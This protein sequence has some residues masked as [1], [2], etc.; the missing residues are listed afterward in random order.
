MTCKYSGCTGLTSIEISN[1][2]TSIGDYAFC[3]CTGLTSI[4]IPNSVISIGDDAFRG[5]TGL[6]RVE[7]NCP[8]VDCCWSNDFTY[9]ETIIEK[10]CGKKEGIIA[11]NIKLFN[12]EGD[13]LFN[14]SKIE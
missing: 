10:E 7:L 12:N 13:I 1:S 3:G 6:K 5:C 9:T 4:T 11:T 14:S 8:M 2:V